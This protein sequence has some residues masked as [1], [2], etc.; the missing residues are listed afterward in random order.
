MALHSPLKRGMSNGDAMQAIGRVCLERF[1]DQVQAVRDARA[2]EGVHQARVALRRLRAGMSLFKP[3]LGDPESRRVNADLWTIAAELGK[4][5]DLDVMLKRLRDLALPEHIDLQPLITAFEAERAQAYDGVIAALANDRLERLVEETAAWVETGHWLNGADRAHAKVRDKS[6]ERF[7]GD[8]LGRRTRKLRRSAKHLGDLDV[9][10]RHGVRIKAKKVRYG[11]E[12]FAPLAE[13]K[14]QRRAAKAFI[15]ALRPLQDCLGGLND[16][17]TASVML[18]EAGH[19][20]DAARVG[21]AAGAAVEAIELNQDDL[22]KG[23]EKAASR[24]MK[25]KPFLD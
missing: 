13:D 12:F 20:E 17:A 18:R 25:A 21:Y 22:L 15:G 23:A 11:A 24:F 19:G 7:A 8:E 10:E 3:M 4:A 5:R 9:R 16:I 6:V 14:D 1:V 2:P